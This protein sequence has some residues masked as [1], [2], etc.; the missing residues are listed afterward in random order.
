MKQRRNNV[1]GVTWEDIK[2]SDPRNHFKVIKRTRNLNIPGNSL[3]RKTQEIDPW[4]FLETVHDQL[5]V[6]KIH[7]G[8]QETNKAV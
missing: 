2:Y 7:P 1:T 6:T 4:N 3:P 8:L 5:M